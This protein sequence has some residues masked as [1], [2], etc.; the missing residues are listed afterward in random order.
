[1]TLNTFRWS[2]S[3]KHLNVV[4][5]KAVSYNHGNIYFTSDKVPTFY[6]FFKAKGNKLTPPPTLRASCM[7]KIATMIYEPFHIF[8]IAVIHYRL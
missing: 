5:F 1:M 3:I 2:F 4:E 6:T 8:H 7:I